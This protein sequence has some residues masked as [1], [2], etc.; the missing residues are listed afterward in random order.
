VTRKIHGRIVIILVAIAALGWAA[1]P[2]ARDS[3]DNAREA[4]EK[5]VETRKT[6]SKEKQD[7]ALE[8]E[9]LEERIQLVQREI[10][11]LREK[12]SEAEKSISDTDE[13]RAQLMEE[14]NKLK[15][16][17]ETLTGIVTKLEAKTVALNKQLPDPIRERVKP[18]SQ[19]LPD[20][21]ND[22]QLSLAQR[23]QNVI[24]VLNEVNKF[25]LEITVTSER[26]TIA[27]GKEA[28]VTALY[29]GLGQAYYT[30][31]NGSVAGVG[32]PS[33]EGW[34]WIPANDQADKVA[35]AVAI[36]KNEMVAGFVPLPVKVK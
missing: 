2:A 22:T 13:K 5:W 25:N 10:T 20:D 11:S 16:A 21:P 12:I 36:L 30:G 14:N 4:L 33:E 1:E 31:A 24:G 32:R 35:D 23:F 6:I 18:V 3:V 28:E 19:L 17:S 9:I 26:R 8:R 27:G 34:N 29:V 15:S 7:W